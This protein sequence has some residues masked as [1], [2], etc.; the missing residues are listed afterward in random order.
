LL[1]TATRLRRHYRSW[2]ASDR[3]LI[4]IPRHW[5][6]VFLFAYW[7][8]IAEEALPG[9]SRIPEYCRRVNRLLPNFPAQQDAEGMH[10]FGGLISAD[11]VRHIWMAAIILSLKTSGLAAGIIFTSCQFRRS[12]LRWS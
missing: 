8:I 12:S 11:A 2:S 6:S 7:A 1:I 4:P 3:Q 10:F 5:A 9:S